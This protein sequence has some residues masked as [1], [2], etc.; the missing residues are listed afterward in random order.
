MAQGYHI[1]ASV[2][3]DGELVN[4]GKN[5]APPPPKPAQPRD[6]SYGA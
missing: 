2:Q 5:D 4:R 6:P 1:C 3:A